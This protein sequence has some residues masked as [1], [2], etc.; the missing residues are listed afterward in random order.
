[1]VGVTPLGVYFG[2]AQI[3]A[4]RSGGSPPDTLDEGRNKVHPMVMSLGRN[5]FYKNEKLTAVCHSPP[6]HHIALITSLCLVLRNTGNPHHAS[7]QLR[8]LRTG[9]EGHRAW[10]HSP[11]IGLH[12]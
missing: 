10:I 12:I 8:L 2:Y 11:R 5:P 7:V 6:F 1:M 3:P 4:N 9:D